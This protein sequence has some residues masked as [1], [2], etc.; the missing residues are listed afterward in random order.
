[1]QKVPPYSAANP[2]KIVKNMTEAFLH[3]KNKKSQEEFFYLS[4]AGEAQKM[5]RSV[6]AVQTFGKKVMAE[7][8]TCIHEKE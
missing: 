8:C 7:I 1:V 3:K 2:K 5:S 4:R 6:E